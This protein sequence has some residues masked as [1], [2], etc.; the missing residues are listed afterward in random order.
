MG[1]PLACPDSSVT[2]LAPS[3]AARQALC[4][5]VATG[6]ATLSA[7]NIDLTHPVTVELTD[8]LA[9]GCMGVYHCGEDRIELLNPDAMKTERKPESSL[10]F[11]KTDAYFQSVLTHELAHAA[12][13]KAPCPFDTCM[14]TSEY[15][16]HVL[17]VMALPD[18]DIDRFEAQLDLTERLSREALNPFLYLMAPDAF[19]RRAWVY[20][21]QQADACG[22]IA[23]IMD[24]K[25]ILDYER[26]E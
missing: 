1:D 21:R 19:L 25:V 6:L 24:G 20:S 17:Q 5:R 12:Y 13:S 8:S 26:F 9:P 23:D 7:C 11:V 4:T 22:H 16:A 15:V 2:V 18:A 14:A 3:H 10:A